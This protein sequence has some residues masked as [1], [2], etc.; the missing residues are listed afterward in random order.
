MIATILTTVGLVLLVLL[1]LIVLIPDTRGHEAQREASKRAHD[2]AQA[3]YRRQLDECNRICP[4]LN[5][6]P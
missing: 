5:L 3:R 1:V 2:E 6:K 4:G